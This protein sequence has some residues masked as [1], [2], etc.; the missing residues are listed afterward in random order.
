MLH[1]EQ[2]DGTIEEWDAILETFPD[3]EI[4]QTSAWIRFLAESQNAKPVIAVSEGRQ[5]R[6]SA[7]S[8][9]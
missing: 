4:F 3:R 6:S 9:A 7:T 2:F 8:R 1:F 5:R